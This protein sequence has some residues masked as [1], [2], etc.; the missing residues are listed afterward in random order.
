MPES[1]LRFFGCITRDI[2]VE[3]WAPVVVKDATV[4]GYI[5]SKL[6]A[7]ASGDTNDAPNYYQ[8]YI[9]E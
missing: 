2:E 5:D 6:L 7:N 8:D 1:I 4:Y 3:S 9:D